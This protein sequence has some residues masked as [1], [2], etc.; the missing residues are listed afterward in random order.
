MVKRVTSERARTSIEVA[1]AYTLA[2]G[3]AS[4]LYHL[5]AVPFVHANLHALVAA[6]F[7][8]L[9]QLILR[10]RGDVGEYGFT[11]HPRALG[12]AI[13]F[14]AMVLILP[15]FIGGFVAYGRALC[16]WA[17]R[18]APSSCARILHP[19]LRLPSG[20]AMLVAAQLI[21]IALPEELF[22]RGYL[23]TRLEQAWPPRWKLWGAPVG[24]AWIATAALFGLGHFLVTFEPQ[25]LSRFF[26]GLVFGWMYARTRSIMASTLFH[27]ACNVLMDV[28]AHSFYG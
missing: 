21:V 3:I 6:V 8:L 22:F 5:Q 17:P 28:L 7:L 20:F 1:V 4:A 14:G 11:T 15:I 13:A 25:M 9:P 24:G 16:A 10:R 18:L 2:T 19:H 12:L 27:A 26:P 23:Q